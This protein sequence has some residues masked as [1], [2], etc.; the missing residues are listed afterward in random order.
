MHLHIIKDV[1]KNI[2]PC[3]D[4][5]LWQAADQAACVHGVS[6]PFAIPC[7]VPYRWFPKGG[8]LNTKQGD[9]SGRISVDEYLA[10]A[11][12]YKEGRPWRGN[13]NNNKNNNNNNGGRTSQEN[14][15]KPA[16]KPAAPKPAPAAPRPAAATPA[17]RPQ[18]GSQNWNPFNFFG[19]FG[20]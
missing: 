20:R 9:G 16:P 5:S 6:T 2:E 13:Q 19:L 17:P 7:C 15:P 4:C 8:F 18:A 3:S 11:K 10:R 14:A 1:T 12:A